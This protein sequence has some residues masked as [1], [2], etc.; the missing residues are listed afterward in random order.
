[1]PDCC[2][3]LASIRVVV[4]EKSACTEPVYFADIRVYLDFTAHTKDFR[5]RRSTIPMISVLVA[6]KRR[7]EDMR[8]TETSTVTLELNPTIRVFCEEEGW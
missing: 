8:P 7:R 5:Y 4:V 1:M 2:E 3:D 6:R